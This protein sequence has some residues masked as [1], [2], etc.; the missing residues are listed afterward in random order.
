MTEFGLNASI[1][2]PTFWLLQV[3][4]TFFVI[5][6]VDN[7]LIRGKDTHFSKVIAYMEEVRSSGTTSSFLG[8]GFYS[9]PTVRESFTK[10]QKSDFGPFPENLLAHRPPDA[11]ATALEARFFSSTEGSMLF[12]GRVTTPLLA[13]YAISFGAKAKKLTVTHI[14]QLSNTVLS[15]RKWDFLLT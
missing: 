12:V 11:P 7:Y 8:L 4:K 15:S 10:T 6:K 3:G 13:F 5:V 2:D 9:C 1:L 14:K